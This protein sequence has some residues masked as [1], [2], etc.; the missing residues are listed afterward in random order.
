MTQIAGPAVRLAS[1][2]APRTRPR[3]GFAPGILSPTVVLARGRRRATADCARPLRARAGGG[4]GRRRRDRPV[5]R[6]PTSGCADCLVTDDG[7]AARF[8][9]VL[10]RG[11][12]GRTGDRR[13][14]GAP[15]P[16]AGA[17]SRTQVSTTRPRA[18]RETPHS[19]Q[20]TVETIKDDLIRIGIVAFL[21]NFVLL[22]LFLRAIVAPLYLVLASTLGARGHDRDH[23]A[24][25][26]GLP[27]PR[28]ADLPRAVRGRSAA[29]LAGIGLQRLRRREDLAGGRGPAAARGDRH[30]RAPGFTRHRR[31]RARAR[32]LVRD[33]RVH[34][35]AA[36]PRVRVRDVPSA[37]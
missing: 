30:R 21:V 24:R 11:A 27:R 35:P 8:L 20:E 15:R 17:R 19:P 22:A 7:D 12:A 9:L 2:A 31:R 18:S 4:A 32:A 33:A 16:A 36:V 25:L 5:A 14:E 13:G 3:K 10:D 29:A 34:R 28:R 6:R 26:P 23:D 37:S 1:R